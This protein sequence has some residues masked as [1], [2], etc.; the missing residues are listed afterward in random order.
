MR[1]NVVD[2]NPLK[3]DV[4]DPRP[5]MA[6]CIYNLQQFMKSSESSFLYV[7]RG[8]VKVSNHFSVCW[9]VLKQF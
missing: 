5:V 2:M 4:Y 9:D 3:F 6:S 8:F 7:T 1:S